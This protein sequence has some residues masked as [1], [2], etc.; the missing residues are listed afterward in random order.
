MLKTRL[1]LFRNLPQGATVVEVG[2]LNGGFLDEIMTA[3]PDLKY[4]GVDSWLGRFEGHK[5][6]AYAKASRH[7]NA[8]LLCMDSREAA[9]M[10]SHASAS[11]C[12]GNCDLVYIDGNHTRQEFGLDLIRWMEAVKKGGIL[13]GHDY[14]T[15]PPM[16]GWEAIE[17][18]DTLDEWAKFAGWDVNVIQENAPSWWV[19]L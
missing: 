14:E 18:K 19:Q 15:K 3:R 16:D 10:F 12:F 7:K 13:S 11:E 1:D 5:A 8:S 17:V 6:D 9:Q 4:F 2:V